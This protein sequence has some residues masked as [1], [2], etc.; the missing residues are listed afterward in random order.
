MKAIGR[1]IL[2]PMMGAVSIALVAALL[3]SPADA[4]RRNHKFHN[5]LPDYGTGRVMTWKQDFRDSPLQLAD[6]YDNDS[7][8]VS[9][10]DAADIAQSQYPD[11]KVLKVNLL[12]SGVYAVTLKQG[13]N[14]SRVRVNAQT[15][16]IQ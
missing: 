1:R 5:W 15:G 4:G 7:Y 14:V 6:S 16:A 9:A 13:G 2:G 3:A 12:P 8:P 10:A 11:A